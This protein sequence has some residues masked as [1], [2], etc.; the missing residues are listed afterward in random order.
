MKQNILLTNDD[1]YQSVGFF[2]L[3]KELAQD[4]NVVAMAPDGPR[5]WMGKSISRNK[6]IEVKEVD[7]EGIKIFACSGTPADCTQIGIYD[8][9][10]EKPDLVISGINT[11]T[12]IGH[13]RILSSGT[14]GA[15]MEASI[16][17]I[18]AMSSSL[19]ISPEVRNQTDFFDPNNY[20][21]Y[22]NAAKITKKVAHIILENQFDDEVDLISV[23]IPYKAD[24]NSEIAITKPFKEA[25]GKLFHKRGN[26]YIHQRPPLDI[27]NMYDNTDMKA[28][29]EEKISIT[30]INLELVSK[31]SMS[32]VEKIFNKN[33]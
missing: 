21:I 12:N 14:V 25:Y 7:I 5:S 29:A 33:W 28:L 31:N 32:V 30:P 8:F 23:N 27:H 9:F 2:P 10:K 22:E 20:S 13:G 1:G 24:L 17:G 15:A 19:F 11:G 6:K 26:R 16:D 3:L 18:K 4:F